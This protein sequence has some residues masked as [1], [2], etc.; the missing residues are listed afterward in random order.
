[1]SGGGSSGG[2]GGI[3]VTKQ[4]FEP[5]EKQARAQVFDAAGDAFKAQTS[6]VQGT[7]TP[8]TPAV[9]AQP[10]VTAQAAVPGRYVNTGSSARGIPNRVWQPGT[11][12]IAG[13][14]AVAAQAAIP[15]TGGNANTPAGNFNPASAP[16]PFDP[17]TLQSQDQLLNFALGQGQAGVNDIQ[18]S[19]SY[20]LNE[21]R[22][23]LNNPALISLLESTNRRLFDQ[24]TD[25]GGALSQIRDQS[26][27]AGQYG[28]TRQGIGEGI[29]AGR[30]AEVLGDTS[31]Q[32]INNAY[33]TGQ[34]TFGRTLALA[35]QS[36]QTGALPATFTGAVGA[37]RENKAQ[38]FEDFAASG[39]AFDLNAPFIPVQNFANIVN[40]TI[41]PGVLNSNS[42][43]GGSSSG[44]IGGILG[45]TA[46]GAMAGSAAGPYGALAGR[47]IGLLGGL[48]G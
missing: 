15:G 11:P 46:S 35:P 13:Q 47:A 48:F 14:P 16:V 20:G 9:A 39:R 18:N 21:A 44:G 36:L 25:P 24:F 30:F 41:T 7:G 42:A 45:G 31:A 38:Q 2:G 28:G 22:D 33:N 26:L 17:L 27:Q 19:L 23:P 4:L 34:E 1:M 10:A 32:I 29:A 8:G 12:A 43:T 6:A 3:S 5:Q 40:G 37:Q